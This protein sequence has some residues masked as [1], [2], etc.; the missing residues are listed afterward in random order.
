MAERFMQMSTNEDPAVAPVIKP[1]TAAIDTE[2][3][4]AVEYRKNNTVQQFRD[5]ES[6]RDNFTMF[7]TGTGP[8]DY[9]KWKEKKERDLQLEQETL[10]P[11]GDQVQKLKLAGIR[12]ES[13]AGLF[14]GVTDN[15]S[16][17]MRDALLNNPLNYS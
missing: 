6:H 11:E 1:Q 7:T 9:R 13:P 5:L 16:K 2:R 10:L 4:K 14:W 3:E 12:R 17:E 15:T 8:E